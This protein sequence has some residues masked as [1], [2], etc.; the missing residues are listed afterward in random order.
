[1][2]KTLPESKERDAR[3]RELASSLILV[4]QHTRGYS[5]AETDEVPSQARALAEKSTAPASS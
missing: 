2:L 1:M 3:E 5:A 4:L